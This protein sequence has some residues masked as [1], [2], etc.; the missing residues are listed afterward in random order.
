[1]KCNCIYNYSKNKNPK[2][3]YDYVTKNLNIIKVLIFLENTKNVLFLFITLDIRD[4]AF[5]SSTHNFTNSGKKSVQHTNF[6]LHSHL[7]IAASCVTA[8]ITH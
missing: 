3:L 8:T 7:I 6:L 4:G 2:R 5:C 1:M